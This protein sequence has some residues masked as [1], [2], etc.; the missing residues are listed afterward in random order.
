MLVIASGLGTL[1]FIAKCW[2]ECMVHAET[3]E[4]SDTVSWVA[5]FG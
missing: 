1:L 5:V 2:L 4:V 3:R